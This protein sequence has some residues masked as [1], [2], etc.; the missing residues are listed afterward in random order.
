[1][2]GGGRNRDRARDSRAESLREDIESLRG[3][4]APA[5]DAATPRAKTTRAAAKAA[6]RATRRTKKGPK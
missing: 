4:R 2:S 6:R 5:P 3:G 1:M